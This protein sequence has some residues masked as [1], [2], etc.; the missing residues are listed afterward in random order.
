MLWPLPPVPAVLALHRPWSARRPCQLALR[1]LSHLPTC[2]RLTLLNASAVGSAERWDAELNYLRLVTD[3]LAAA[4]QA[5]AGATGGSDSGGSASAGGD[6]GGS[7]GGDAAAAARA[8]VL[9]ANPR[10][11]ALT[12]VRRGRT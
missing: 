3:E 7:T 10:F 6:A 2:S 8:A 4:E 12:Q 9:A 11:G 1:A 5:A